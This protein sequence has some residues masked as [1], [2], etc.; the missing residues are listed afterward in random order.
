MGPTSH[1]VTTAP[2]FL[3]TWAP[4]SSSSSPQAG[5]PHPPLRCGPHLPP[6]DDA[7][8]HHSLTSPAPHLRRTSPPPRGASWPSDARGATTSTSSGRGGS[9]G[10]LRGGAGW[11]AWIACTWRGA[12]AATSCVG[13]G[14]GALEK[15]QG[16]RPLNSR[17]LAA[18]WG[19]RRLGGKRRGLS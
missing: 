14:G 13:V 15:A 10:W 5:R 16:G 17:Q 3:A 19:P 18:M 12:R 8:F 7:L 9:D 11:T 1:H 4:S 2:R 6:P